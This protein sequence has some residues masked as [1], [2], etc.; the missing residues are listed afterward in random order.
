MPINIDKICIWMY[1]KVYDFCTVR[2]RFY[3]NYI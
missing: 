1:K 3:A 2:E